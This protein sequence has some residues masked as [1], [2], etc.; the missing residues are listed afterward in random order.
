[1]ALPPELAAQFAIVVGDGYRRFG[2]PVLAMDAYQVAIATATGAGLHEYVAR[3][4]AGR[5]AVREVPA[6]VPAV[7]LP[8]TLSDVIAAVEAMHADGRRRERPASADRVR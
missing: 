5:A 6:A 3:A 2:Q 4:D 7:T 1:V 8:E